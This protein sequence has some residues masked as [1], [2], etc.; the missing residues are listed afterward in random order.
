V[1]LGEIELSLP[2]RGAAAGPVKVAVRPESLRLFTASPAGPALEGRIAKA[3]YLGTHMEYTV[4]TAVGELFVVDRSVTRPAPAG[5]PVW[6]AF[7]DH[8]VTVVPDRDRP[9][10]S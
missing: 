4:S 10:T 2:H 5:T 7:E 3:A 1:R 8:G 9:P 6:V